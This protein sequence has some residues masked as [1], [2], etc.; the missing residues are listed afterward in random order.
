LVKM[1]ENTP[2][3]PLASDESGGGSVGGL[4]AFLGRGLRH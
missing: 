2:A 4:H 1:H 3:A